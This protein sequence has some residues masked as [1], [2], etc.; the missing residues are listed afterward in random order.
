MKVSRFLAIFLLAA[1]PTILLSQ[2]DSS[3]LEFDTDFRFRIEQDWNGL[4]DDGAKYDDRSRLRFRYR[5]GLNYQYN[6]WASFGFRLRSGALDDQQ[7]PHLTLGSGTGEFSLFQIGFEKAFFKAENERIKLW[8]GKNTF[9]FWK[10]NELFWNNN[11]YPDGAAISLKVR[12]KVSNS[13]LLQINLGHFII[14]SSGK[15]FWDDA[16]F[17]GAQ[18]VFKSPDTKLRIAPAFYN[19]R[20]LGNIPDQNGSYTLDYAIGQ[21]S[22]EYNFKSELPLKIGAELYNNFVDYGKNDSVPLSMQ[23][24]TFGWVINAKLGKTKAKGDWALWLYYANLEKYSIVDYFA[25]NDWARWDYSSTGSTGSKIS[26]FR[27]I[28]S[29]IIYTFGP[30]FN[31]TLRIYYTERLMK[32]GI[33][34]GRNSRARLDLNIKF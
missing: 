27:G 18:L 26:N 4:K 20:K 34:N 24:E 14:R 2:S 3:K 16:Y 25:Q 7:G 28:E 19:F 31:L 15:L 5:F 30:K 22:A 23:S 11:V 21:L 13:Q 6:E 8:L 9:P 12:K 1:M 29:R 32:E 17:N 33:A 10:Q